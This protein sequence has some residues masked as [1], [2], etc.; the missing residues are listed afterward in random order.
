MMGLDMYLNTLPKIDGYDLDQL[1]AINE[2]ICESG[3]KTKRDYKKIVGDTVYNH[4]KQK[5]T[6]GIFTW[7]AIEKEVAYW[8][9]SNHIHNWF[10]QNVQN[11]IDKC[12]AHSVTEE[13]I[14]DL[15]TVVNDVLKAKDTATSE[16]LLPVQR[17]FFF[18]GTDY[19][20]W[21]Y[22]DLKET[23]KNLNKILQTVD[24]ENNYLVYQSSW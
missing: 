8:R 14:I 7:Y 15:L 13:T 3:F 12:Q 2:D 1:I 10:V 21:Y 23:K 19:D 24:F 20:E 6:S 18:G 16:R 9:K 17:G 4:I 5:G 22:H 11:G